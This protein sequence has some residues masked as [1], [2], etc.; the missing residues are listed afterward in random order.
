MQI[1]SADETENR[2]EVEIDG[3]K[4]WAGEKYS[5]LELGYAFY[6]LF[7]EDEKWLR[8]N[9]E[10]LPAD[11]YENRGE[12]LSV[13]GR[14]ITSDP[15]LVALAI[16]SYWYHQKSS[17][18]K[19]VFIP[20]LNEAIN[21]VRTRKILIASNKIWQGYVPGLDR[22]VSKNQVN[23]ELDAELNIPESKYSLYRKRRILD[24]WA[25]F[26]K[27]YT[28]RHDL[29]DKPYQTENR[30]PVF[31]PAH[32]WNNVILNP[33]SSEQQIF[34]IKKMIPDGE[35]HKWFRSMS[36][37]QAL[38]L[39]ILGNLQIHGCLGVLHKLC[40]DDNEPIIEIAGPQLGS[41]SMEHKIRHL[42]E[43]RS[44]SLD[45][46]INGDYRIAIECKFTETEVGS[47]SRTRLSKNDNNF[48]KDYCDGSYTF[49]RSRTTRCSLTEIGVKYWDLIPSLFNISNDIDYFHCLIRNNYQLF[50]NILAVGVYEDSTISL[51]KSHVILIYDERNP[52]FGL[53]GKAYISFYETKRALRNP[54]MLRKI[55]WQNII[56][57]LRTECALPWLTEQILD[58]YGI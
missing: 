20:P 44:T 2:L 36:S 38:A 13:N 37:S 30:P 47:C 24:F 4:L 52:S 14:L 16:N 56:S 48:E 41:F 43:P 12:M 9:G 15:I 25:Y 23:N 31:L 55:S 10:I 28:N 26:Q 40:G 54:R 7:E 6:F 46:F 1:Y 57:H 34:A 3:H 35:F 39:S 22:S 42:G 45:G 17:N 27:Y 21:I 58:K 8:E 19:P 11:P 18:P 51:E 5:P 32:S 29:L 53:G 33:N 49:Q 50:R